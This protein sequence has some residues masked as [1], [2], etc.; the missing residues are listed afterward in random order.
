MQHCFSLPLSMMFFV[1]AYHDN[2]LTFARVLW[3]VF[4]WLV[5]GTAMGIIGWYAILPSIRRRS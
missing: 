3:I 4:V 5:A 1:F 2:E